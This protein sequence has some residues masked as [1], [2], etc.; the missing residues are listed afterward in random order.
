[1]KRNK[2][3][4]TKKIAKSSSRLTGKPK[5]KMAHVLHVKKVKTKIGTLY[6]VASHRGLRNVLFTEPELPPILGPKNSDESLNA[7]IIL[8]QA[9]TELKEYFAGKRKTFNLPLDL[10]GTDF[11]KD[12]WNQLKKIPYGTTVSYRDIA[13]KIKNPGAVRAVGSANGKNPVCIVIP[14]HRVIAA[15]GTLGGYT[16]GTDKKIKLLKIE[17]V[18]PPTEE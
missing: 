12:V 15:D 14:C 13:R 18:E 16:G 11:Q 2:K 1:M 10:D 17:R 9:T 4:N 7:K 5:S 8:Q 6:L 3:T